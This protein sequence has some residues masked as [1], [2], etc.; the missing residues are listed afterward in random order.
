MQHRGI[1]FKIVRTRSGWMWMVNAGKTEKVV[2]T[3]GDRTGA[4]RRAKSIIDELVIKR[5]QS[6]D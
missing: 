4:I 5:E 1:E 3:H 6:E 2:G